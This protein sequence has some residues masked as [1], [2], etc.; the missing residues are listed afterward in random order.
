M[1][2]AGT[3]YTPPLGNILAGIT[4]ET[5]IS[6]AWDMGFNVVETN[7]TLEEA[8]HADEAFFTGT[9]AEVTPI[10]SIDDEIICDG[11]IG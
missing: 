1:V 10:R 5:I 3:I 4:R 8:Y 7:I 2:K 6:L 11:R 9:A